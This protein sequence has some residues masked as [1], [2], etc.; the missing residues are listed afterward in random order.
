MQL[1]RLV[2]KQHGR[3]RR[4]GV[5]S[6]AV[7]NAMFSYLPETLS[8]IRLPVCLPLSLSVV[9][10]VGAYRSCSCSQLKFSAMFLC[11]FVPYI[12]PSADHHTKFYEDVP[13]EPIRRGL[14]A[15]G[16]AKYSYV[17][18]VECR[19]LYLRNGA[20]Y[21]ASDTINDIIGRKSYP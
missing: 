7:C 3:I 5:T 15:C 1:Q 14:N 11:Y 21:T 6:C 12:Y 17:G 10:N 13:A 19:R 4:L 9:C 18:P 20:R 16:L 2:D 8:K